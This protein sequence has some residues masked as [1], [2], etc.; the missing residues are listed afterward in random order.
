MS[1]RERIRAKATDRYTP[2]GPLANARDTSKAN[3]A[4]LR[5]A[6]A[7][8]PAEVYARDLRASAMGKRARLGTVVVCEEC[9]VAF[10]PLI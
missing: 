6:R 8:S 3:A 10:C 2:T 7:A 4:R 5:A 9:S 1:T